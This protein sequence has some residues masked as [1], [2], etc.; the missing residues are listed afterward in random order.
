MR[1]EDSYLFGDSD[2]AARR[3]AVLADAFGPSSRAFVR[4]AV[5][6]SVELAADLGCGPGRTSHMLAEVTQCNRIVGLDNSEHFISLAKDTAT[7]GVS[8]IK[9]DVTTVPFPAGPFDL[10]YARFLLTHQTKPEKL[11]SRWAGQLQ[12]GGRLLSEEVETINSPEPAFADY[13][14]IVEAMLADS[15]HTLCVGPRLDSMAPPAGSVRVSS[16]SVRVPIPDRL[17][18]TM[19]SMNIQTWKA[20][21]FVRDNVPSETVGQLAQRLIALASEP[22][23]DTTTEWRLRQ[24]VFERETGK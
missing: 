13:L 4:S 21:A 16:R 8:F 14:G 1:P 10:I 5:T 2:L 20:N 7:A 24:I 11:I 12:P 3:L 19:F 18:A 15:G 23:S 9:H 17:A 6:G 22:E